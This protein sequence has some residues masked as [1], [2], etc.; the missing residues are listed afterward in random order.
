[1][2]TCKKAKNLTSKDFAGR[3]EEKV[4]SLKN[5]LENVSCAYIAAPQ[6]ELEFILG[7]AQHMAE[8]LVRIMQ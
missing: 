1:M 3:L 2:K 7:T 8:R 4:K 6:S 5:G